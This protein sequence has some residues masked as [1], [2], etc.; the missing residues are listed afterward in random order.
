[1]KYPIIIIGSGPVGIRA[2]EELA[3]RNPSL[4]FSLYGDEPCEP[5]NRVQLSSLLAGKECY[6]DIKIFPDIKDKS[7]LT[8]YFNCPIIQIDADNKRVHRADGKTEHYDKL[9]IATGSHAHVPSIPNINI[10][11][12]FTF[13]N[14][15]DA[16][17]LKSRNS[18]ATIVLGGGLLGLETARALQ[19]QST[20]VI[21]I[22]HSINLMNRQLDKAAGDLLMEKVLDLGIQVILADGVARILGAECI[23]GVQLRSGRTLS[24]DTLVLAVG[25]RP[26][27]E[28]A[29]QAELKTIRGIVVNEKM[30]TSEPDIYAIGE[31]AEFQ[32]ITYGIVVPGFEQAIVMA[33]NLAG[34]NNNYTGSIVATR[35]KVLDYPVFSM[36]QVAENETGIPLKE[37]CY[38]NS[39]NYVYRK[40]V[41]D[42]HRLTG[43]I[44]LGGWSELSRIRTAIEQQQRFWPWQLKRFTG[45]GLLW[46]DKDADSIVYWPESAIVCNCSQVTRGQL[47]K[48]I[49]QGCHTV[50]AL[51]EK[52]KAATVCGSC[53]SLLSELLGSRISPVRAF[54]TLGF[55][56]VLAF[57]AGCAYFLFPV[58]PYQKIATVEWFIDEL[59]RNNLYKQISG[60]S[61]LA[62]SVLVLLLSLRKRIKSF[63]WLDFALWR[64]MHV[65]IGFLA[66]AIL[67]LHTGLRFGENLNF[68]VMLSFSGLIVPG[69]LTGAVIALEHKMNPGMARTLRARFLWLHTVLFWPLPVLL[70]FHILQTYYF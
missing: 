43:C 55:F 46:A 41:L 8:T 11:G 28:L 56:S 19:K 33:D 27:I 40:L 51:S 37:H 63:Q 29:R 2:I 22:D 14:L 53:H 20:Q 3:V 60:Y 44:T 59:W 61:L 38:K 68:Y 62:C 5:Y 57:F 42:G 70:G 12:V 32:G 69:S 7:R 1:M 18:A 26:N 23:E 36:G 58:F 35:L 48:A 25:I 6:E 52:T 47:S 54:K 66:L 49:N 30:Q 24:C 17:T 50:C 67:L 31:C 34:R 45:T 15:K 9:V 64:I 21:V 39:A 65:S 16:D 4:T 10:A 13:R